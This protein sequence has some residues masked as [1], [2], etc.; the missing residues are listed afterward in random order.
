LVD[1]LDMARLRDCLPRSR[2][3]LCIQPALIDWS[4]S[5]SPA[6]E[7]ALGEASTVAR[8]VLSRWNAI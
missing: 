1:L 7:A 2:A 3:L 5:L 4:E 8:A 6:V